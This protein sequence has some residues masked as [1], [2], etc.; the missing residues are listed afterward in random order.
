MHY[1]GIPRHTQSM[2]ANKVLTEYFWKLQQKICFLGMLLTSPID[3]VT[4]ILWQDDI[5]PSKNTPTY[6]SM[7]LSFFC[8]LLVNGC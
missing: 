6:L 1:F 5:Q 8:G 4:N 7:I 3:N 2:T